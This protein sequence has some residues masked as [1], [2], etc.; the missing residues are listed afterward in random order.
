MESLLGLL[1]IETPMLFV[2]ESITRNTKLD[3]SDMVTTSP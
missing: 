1:W 2:E 3:F